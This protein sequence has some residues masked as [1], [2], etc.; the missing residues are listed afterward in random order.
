MAVATAVPD[1]SPNDYD[2]VRPF[3]WTRPLLRQLIAAGVV[4][5]GDRVELIEGELVVTPVQNEPHVVASELTEDVL[6]AAFGAGYHVRGQRPV[7]LGDVS[8]PEPDIAVVP[9]SI[10]E[11]L[12]HHPTPEAVA[13][14]VEV[15][16]TT[17]RY[18]RLRKMSLYAKYGI[19]EAWIVNLPERILEV[20]REPAAD[21]MAWYGFSY[22]SRTVVPPDGP[23]APLSAPDKPI[24]AA[25]L[26]P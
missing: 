6:R 24:S 21:P 14:L 1:S 17:L 7:A 2:A 26:L 16:D 19:K 20:Y 18:D 5:E 11:Y 10:R 22:H 9:G 8:E 12:D 4:R 3:V 15:S 23:I 25:D 13:L